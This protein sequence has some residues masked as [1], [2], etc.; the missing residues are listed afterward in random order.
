MRDSPVVKKGNIFS[1]IYKHLPYLWDVYHKL[2]LLLTESYS[3]NI[4]FFTAPC[5]EDDVSF[6]SS[7]RAKLDL[8]FQNG[9]VRLTK[10]GEQKFWHLMLGDEADLL[11]PLLYLLKRRLFLHGGLILKF[12]F[13]SLYFANSRQFGFI[14]GLDFPNFTQTT[15]HT[16]L[17]NLK[18]KR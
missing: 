18:I 11:L 9:G 13:F 12:I 2:Q 8:N 5:S 15:H 17:T 10:R 1:F 6:A 4:P 3:K 7:C 16:C 14:S